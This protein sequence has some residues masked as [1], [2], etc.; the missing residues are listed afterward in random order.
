MKMYIKNAKLCKLGTSLYVLNKDGKFIELDDIIIKNSD[1]F[2]EKSSE[3]VIVDL[4]ITI[5]E[6]KFSVTCEEEP[7]GGDGF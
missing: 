2:N 1:L 4:E 5:K 3:E 6:N 7:Q